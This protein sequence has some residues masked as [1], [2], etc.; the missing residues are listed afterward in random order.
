MTTARIILGSRSPRR[1][2]LLTA[3]GLAFESSEAMLD[4][5]AFHSP[6]PRA[7]VMKTA[8]AKAEA[9]AAESERDAIVIAADT[10]VALDGEIFNKPDSREHAAW[11]LRQLSGKT[12]SVWTG[13]A[14]QRVGSETIL[15]AVEARV[16]CC[17]LSDAQIHD[18]VATG[19]ADDKA[20]A[21]GIQELG[22]DF[23][24]AVEGDLSCVVGLPMVRLREML[25]EF[26]GCD[27][28]G[29]RGVREIVLAAYPDLLQL[30]DLCLS[31]DILKA[32]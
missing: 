21:Y 17:T 29:G 9:V 20:G 19:K 28:F 11:M 23:M 5:S 24:A 10:S 8:L 4:E 16:H 7:S 1:R 13:L 22:P 30:A 15:D 27:P 18:Y 32:R 25:G 26:L 12:H 31:F 2:A 14:L 6:Q 3:A